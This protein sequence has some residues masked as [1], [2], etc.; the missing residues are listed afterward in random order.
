M[1]DDRRAVTRRGAVWSIVV[2]TSLGV[3]LATPFAL[4]SLAPEG[5]DW[6]RLSAVSQT[7]GAVS[8]FISAAALAGVALSLAYQA[9]QTRIQNGEAHRSAHRELVLLTLSDP[10]YQV[11]WEP[12]NTPMTQERWKQLLVANLIVSMWS[13]DYKLGL[14]DDHLLRAVLEDYFRGEIGRA[15]WH[16]SGPSWHRYFARSGDRHERRFLALAEDAYRTA[17]AAGPAVPA[18]E[19][20]RPPGD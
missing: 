3:I 10:A 15:Y 1:S 4:S 8:V 19:Y 9:R 17:V 16:N 5:T 7:Y 12:P 2:L 11:C 14:M 18:A 20:F 6:E 13:T